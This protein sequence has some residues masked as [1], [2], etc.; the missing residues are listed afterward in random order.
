MG[1]QYDS[2]HRWLHQAFV[3]KYER[4]WKFDPAVFLPP[5]FTKYSHL[6]PLSIRYHESR[7]KSRGLAAA[8]EKPWRRGG[9]ESCG[10]VLK[11]KFFRRRQFH[12]RDVGPVQLIMVHICSTNF[13]CSERTR[14]DTFATYIRRKW[15]VIFS[16]WQTI[17][18]VYM[19]L[20][21]TFLI[22]STYVCQVK[23]DKLSK[24]KSMRPPAPLDV[25]FSFDRLICDIYVFTWR[26]SLGVEQ[27]FYAPMYVG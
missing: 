6:S 1:K 25:F 9:L 14:P 23:R 4:I 26:V 24:R 7:I 3:N 8:M 10:C 16:S 13:Y 11:I 5:L 20:S 19:G 18:E 15:P 2:L 17:I 21:H 12:S 22:D 27:L